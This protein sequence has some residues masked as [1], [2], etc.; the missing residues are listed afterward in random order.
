MLFIHLYHVYGT[1]SW[2]RLMR[3]RSDKIWLFQI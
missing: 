2:W 3:K 1:T